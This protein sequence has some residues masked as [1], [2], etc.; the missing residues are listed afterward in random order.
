MSTASGT[1]A[2]RLAVDYQLLGSQTNFV[3]V[4][5]RADAAKASEQAQLHQVSSMLAAGWGASSDMKASVVRHRIP[6]M[7]RTADRAVPRIQL[8]VSMDAFS[9]SERDYASIAPVPDFLLPSSMR[10]QEAPVHAE[11]APLATI[12]MA[13]VDHLAHGGQV[14]GLAAHCQSLSLHPDARQAL[15]EV[16]ALGLTDGQ[17]LLLLAHWANVRTD[18]LASSFITASL[19]PHVDG[20]DQA[21]IGGAFGVFDSLLAGCANDGWESARSRRLQQ[22]LDQL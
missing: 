13:V 5:R 1:D 9:A 11:A 21:S 2:L 8:S 3:L 19:Q 16:M 17:A 12:A 4:H 10:V 14:R 18:G 6:T 20:L 22:Y 15:D 7:W